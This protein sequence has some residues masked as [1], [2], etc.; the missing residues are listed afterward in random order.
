R[1]TDNPARDRFPSWTSDGRIVFDRY[2]SGPQCAAGTDVYIMNADGTGE[3]NLT[4]NPAVDCVA[5]GSS[6]GRIAFTSDRD[7]NFEIYSMNLDGT[8]VT[9]ITNRPDYFDFWPN[10]SPDAARIVFLGDNTGLD[11][12]VYVM[13]ADG[14]GVTDL[15]NTPDRAEFKP[16]WSP[17]GD[18]I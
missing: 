1:L 6:A 7:G 3:M 13:N 5:N 10:W 15:T 2:P 11:N 12:D 17:Q 4:A 9:R 16:A 8:G 18:K 14:T